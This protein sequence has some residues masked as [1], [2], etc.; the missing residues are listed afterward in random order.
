MEAVTEAL[1]DVFGRPMTPE[2]TLTALRG[3]I[4]LSDQEIARALQGTDRS[5]KRWRA[6]EAISTDSLE[7][8]FD[9]ATVVAALAEYKLPAPN[10]RAWFFYRNRFLGG[11]RPI[12]AFADGGFDALK[13]ALDAVN[14]G[15]YA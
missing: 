6:G 15:A 5:V 13:P 14:D 3:E 9:L 12:D 11:Q 4:G 2:D 10:I 8:L 1:A 7:S